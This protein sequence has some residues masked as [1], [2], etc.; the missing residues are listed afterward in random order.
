MTIVPV[1][2]DVDFGVDPIEDFYA[3]TAA[4]QAAGRRVAPVRFNGGI[5]WLIL[6]YSDL[7]E[8]S[9]P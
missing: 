4:L 8:E 1:M 5:G 7:A 9:H 3:R 6:K 2:S